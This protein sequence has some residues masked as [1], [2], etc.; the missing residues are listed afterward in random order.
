VI[1][2]AIL[3]SGFSTPR[4]V[5]LQSIHTTE[6]NLSDPTSP[7]QILYLTFDGVLEPLGRS[8][9]IGY[10]TG[11]ANQGF[12]Y[13]LLSLERDRDLANQDLLAETEDLLAGHGIKW[14]RLPYRQGGAKLVFE[15]IRIMTREALNLIRARPVGLI[16][17][18]AH[19]TAAIACYLR[20]R[21]RTP[22]LFDARGY[23]IDEKAAEGAWFTSSTSYK[24]AKLIERCMFRHASGIVTLTR[25]MA[26]DVR[27]GTLHHD[28]RIPIA[29][30]P[31]CTD[32][33]KFRRDPALTLP[34]PEANKARLAGKLVIGMMG[35]INASYYSKEALHLFRLLRGLREDAHLLWVTRQ[36]DVARILTRDAHISDCDVT[37]VESTHQDMPMWL[38]RMDWGF[39]LLQETLA[40]RGSVPTKLAEMLACEVRPIHYGCNSEIAAIVRDAGSGIS[41]HD[42][43]KDCLERSA[44]HIAFFPSES[45]TLAFGRRYSETLFSLESGVRKYEALIR[46]VLDRR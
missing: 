28:D 3:L 15:N 32:F 38:N 1:A 43:S 21:S 33:A 17:A 31:T 44:R 9:V 25:L 35:A 7:Q 20:F 6:R 45:E 37:I 30:I 29:V 4:L 34:I 23:W 13:T 14:I 12:S 46:E 40:K 41:L 27:S 24:I 18:R 16:H 36:S 8:Q 42:L 10:L 39:L 22:Y 5:Q 26:D 19:V 11:L 2:V